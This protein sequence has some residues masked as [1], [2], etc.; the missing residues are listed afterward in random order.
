ME[1]SL[2][3]ERDA[4]HAT[5]GPTPK[6]RASAQRRTARPDSII[7][8]GSRRSR[9]VGVTLRTTTTWLRRQIRTNQVGRFKK[10][11]GGDAHSLSTL[12]IPAGI[13]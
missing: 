3:P 4:I 1:P 11:L 7:G 13:V 2:D 6:G 9:D 8:P 5:N 10:L 12:G